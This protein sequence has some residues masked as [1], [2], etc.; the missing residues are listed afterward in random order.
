[1][2]HPQWCGKACGECT[3][4]CLLDESIPCSPDCEGLNQV[5]GEPDSIY[6]KS[7]EAITGK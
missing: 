7:C 4:S 2:S 3:S 5:T 6:C 1:M